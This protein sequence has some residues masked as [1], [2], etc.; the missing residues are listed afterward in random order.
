MDTCR[1]LIINRKFVGIHQ[2]LTPFLK[3]V[4][5]NNSNFEMDARPVKK[6]RTKT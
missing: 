1:Q 4:E 2:D 3:Q 6:P 5:P